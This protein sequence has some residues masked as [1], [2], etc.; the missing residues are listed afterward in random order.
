VSVSEGLLSGANVLQTGARP[1][2]IGHSWYMS[3]GR[4]TSCR[5]NA[6]TVSALRPLQSMP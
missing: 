6:V 2:F 4:E 1:L 3:Y 5:I